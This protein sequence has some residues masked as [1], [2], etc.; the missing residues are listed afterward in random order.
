MGTMDSK[1]NCSCQPS[2]KYIFAHKI[3]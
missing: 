2:S 3:H 1:V